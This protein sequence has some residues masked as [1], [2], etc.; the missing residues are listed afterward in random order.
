MPI[1]EISP[2][3]WSEAPQFAVWSPSVTTWP[4]IYNLRGKGTRQL[5]VYS[6]IDLTPVFHTIPASIVPSHLLAQRRGICAIIAVA[7]PIKY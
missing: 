5:C 2:L 6:T 4:E 7:P 1:S 3:M